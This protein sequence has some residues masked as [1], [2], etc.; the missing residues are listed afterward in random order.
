MAWNSRCKCRLDA[1]I[2]N[3]KQRWNDDKC[4]SECNKLVHKGVCD[5]GFIWNPSNCECECECD[6]GEH[7]DY[8]NRKCRKNK[9]WWNKNC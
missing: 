4:R 5:E 1:S 9:N 6:I 8:E 7:L 2:F 3:N